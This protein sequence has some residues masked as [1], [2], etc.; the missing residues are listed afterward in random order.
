MKILCIG[1][2]LTAGMTTS[3]DDY[4]YSS[5]LA[6]TFNQHTWV[7]A[8][9][10]GDEA[11]TFPTRLRRTLTE[12]AAKHRGEYDAVVIWGGTNDCRLMSSTPGDI[13]A[14]LS[15][16]VTIAREHG[17]KHVAI[18]TIPEMKCETIGSGTIQTF[19]KEVNE[20]LRGLD[21]VD[22]V[23]VASE[24]KL[25]ELSDEEKTKWWCDGLHLTKNGYKK[26]AILIGERASWLKRRTAKKK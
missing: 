5:F 18:L 23:D 7:N 25:H 6:K 20:M 16:S 4:P 9:I 22:L 2:S 21:S 17:V 3:A 14:A 26:V 15:C 13:F 10:G 8:G 12:A 1:D 11:I 24:I 19:R